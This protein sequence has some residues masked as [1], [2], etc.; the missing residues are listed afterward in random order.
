MDTSRPA[1][2]REHS[3]RSVTILSEQTV[4]A[5]GPALEPQIDVRVVL[6]WLEAARVV[7][8]GDGMLSFPRVAAMPGL[9]R[10]ARPGTVP[11]QRPSVYIGETNNLRRRMTGYRHPGPT[12]DTNLR[13]NALLRECLV[14][15]GSIEVT[16]ATAAIVY[17]SGEPT[18]LDLN[19]KAG[20]LL[21]ENAALLTAL[22]KNDAEV[23]NL[24]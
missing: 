19:L 5:S 10:F 14:G 23:I 1:D 15:G 20:R 16:T 11:N 7:L 13:I 18:E 12:Q 3:D 22:A 2:W 8:D 21:A 4:G 6:R 17:L 9:Y 24:G